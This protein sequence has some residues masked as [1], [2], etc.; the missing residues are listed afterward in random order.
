MS[1]VILDVDGVLADF[2]SG[3]RELIISR[4]G[5]MDPLPPEGPP[6]WDWYHLLGAKRQEVVDA[7]AW[8]RDNPAWWATL[9][10][11]QEAV[12]A[13]PLL[14]RLYTERQ[15]IVLTSRVPLHADAITRAWLR[16]HVGLP[17]SVPV[18]HV[19]DKGL[20]IKALGGV[21]HVIDDHPRLGRQLKQLAALSPGDAPPRI[22]QPAWAYNAKTLAYARG[23]LEA[24]IKEV[25]K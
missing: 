5:T 20:A 13:R 2:N 9:R 21:T 17:S 23:P 11:Y 18:V 10:P 4:G 15:V 8:I 22:C 25:L 3:F 7:W 24:M 1:R 19:D 14:Q 12:E 16:A 6:V